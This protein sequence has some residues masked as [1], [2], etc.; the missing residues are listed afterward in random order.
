M[1]HYIHLAE[2]KSTNTYVA[3]QASHLPHGAV[4]YTY[5]QTPGRGQ[6]GN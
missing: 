1:P 2:A 6:K 5:R 4:V 3:E